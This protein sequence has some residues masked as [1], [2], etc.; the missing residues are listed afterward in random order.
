MQAGNSRNSSRDAFPH[1]VACHGTWRGGD[2]NT[3]VHCMAQGIRGR[4]AGHRP[5]DLGPGVH[6]VS[7]GRSA[8]S[9]LP[10]GFSVISLLVASLTDC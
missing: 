6:A 7:Y 2:A 8:H 4:Q 9:C 1:S 10:T 3:R 5:D